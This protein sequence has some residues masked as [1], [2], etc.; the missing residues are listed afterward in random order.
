MQDRRAGTNAEKRSTFQRYT[1]RDDPKMI[2]EYCMTRSATEVP[3]TD[4]Q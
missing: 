1:Y 4:N 3:N 2:A